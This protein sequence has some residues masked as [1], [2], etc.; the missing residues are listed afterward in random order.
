MYKLLKESDAD[1]VH[2]IEA[3]SYP[4][5]E[6]ASLSQIQL[7]LREAHVFFLGAFRE[8]A[9]VGFVNGTLSP[10][11]ELAE[12]TMSSHNPN[13]RFLCIHSVAVD[14]AHRR[15][16]LATAIL[17]HYVE[18]ILTDQ[19]QVEAILLL[20]KPYLAQFYISCGFHVTRLSPVVHGQDAWLEL[21]L[22]CTKARRLPFVQVD[23]FTTERF[24]GNPA[25]V[26]IVPPR[27]YEAPDATSW[28][29]QV[30]KENNVSETAF[31]SPTSSDPC[32]YRLRWFTPA[33]E[34]DLC[35]HGTLATAF[36][37]YE[38]GHAAKDSKLR[39]ET[40]GGVLS[41]RY[42]EATREI[43][44][45]F[46]LGRPE[47]LSRS[48][49]I[50]HDLLASLHL[51][52]ADMVALGVHHGKYLVHVTRHAFTSLLPVDFAKL[53]ALDTKGVAVT[54]DGGVGTPYDYVNRFFNP[55]GGVDE[56]PVTGSAHCVLAAYWGGKLS[57][58]KLRARQ[59]SHRP[60]DIAIQIVG[61]RVLLRG[62]AV[63]TL[64]GT[65]L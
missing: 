34:V 63:M 43:E 17:K 9:L 6:A 46:P 39:F 64:R 61:D 57:K 54:T 62:G 25:A 18:Y 11:R 42:D 29:Q 40:R 33:V 5:D 41:A 24:Q 47:P 27:L 31:V 30:A 37:L 45:D 36:V 53:G 3:A 20:A 58:A 2:R 51:A 60:G 26:V 38:D 15:Q 12:E 59:E 48:D 50:C 13:G 16:G 23:A 7:R 28:M 19:P 52:D 1:E 65:L 10:H 49:P 55:R 56:D 4:S 14:A 35:G 22:E 32:K 44:M 21:V 8:G